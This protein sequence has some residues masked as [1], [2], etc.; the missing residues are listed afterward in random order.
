MS[1]NIELEPVIICRRCR[2]K[3]ITFD[4]SKRGPNGPLI[5][6]DFGTMQPHSDTCEI[7]YSFP[8]SRCSE[9]I[10]LDKKVLSVLGNQI[11]L[12]AID[13]RPHECPGKK[14]S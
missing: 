2:I 14:T 8:C 6:L 9:Q 4:G 13:G 7:G 10:Y 5:P 1:D 11:P 12:N 3:R